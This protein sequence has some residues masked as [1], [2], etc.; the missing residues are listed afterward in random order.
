ASLAQCTGRPHLCCPAVAARR[1]SRISAVGRAGRNGT[2]RGA[3]LCRP[4]RL[5]AEYAITVRSDW[6]GCGLGYFLMTRLIEIARRRGIGELAGEV[7]RENEP[8]LQMYREP[9]FA[10][11]SDL[12]DPGVILIRTQLGEKGLPRS[13]ASAIVHFQ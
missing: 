13:W 7:L 4:D 9:D 12:A 8:M 5:R 10:V 2:W 1:R 3:F 11:S 6:K